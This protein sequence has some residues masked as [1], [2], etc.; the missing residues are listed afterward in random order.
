MVCDFGQ[1]TNVNR[2]LLDSWERFA[3]HQII[4]FGDL[5]TAAWELALKT[6]QLA[7]QINCV[8]NKTRDMFKMESMCRVVNCWNGVLQYEKARSG[9]PLDVLLLSQTNAVFLS[10]LTMFL[11]VAFSSKPIGC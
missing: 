11:Y 8:V 10:D 1:E 3:G 4:D 9:I 7:K 5:L 2:L 6:W